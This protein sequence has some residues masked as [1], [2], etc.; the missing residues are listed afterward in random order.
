[1]EQRHPIKAVALKTG[2]SPHLIRIWERR[3]NAVSP[4]RT[5][6]NRR[7]YSDDDILRL[8][9]LRQAT[10]AGES[11]GQIAH[12]SNDSLTRLVGEEFSVSRPIITGEAAPETAAKISPGEY[13]Q[14]CIEAVARF[15]AERL[16]LLFMKASVSLGQPALMD[17]LLEPL[18]QQI[19][20]LWQDG[21]LKIA[22]EH[23]ASAVVR[24]FLGGMTG[25]FQDHESAP[26]FLA[27]TPA[28]QL[29]ELGALMAVVSARSVG[30]R[31]MYLG[32]NMQA[33]DI[34]FAATA[35]KARVVALS[36]VYPEDDPRIGR[37]LKKLRQLLAADCTIMIGGRAAPAYMPV[38]HEIGAYAS[39]NLGELKDRLIALRAVTNN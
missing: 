12:L 20:D 17:Y 31:G 37:E 18:L 10:I 5:D 21:H 13:V 25:T 6:T 1:M 32:P 4:K 26:H 38:I 39:G 7:M 35:E 9:L 29:H 23:M 28:G 24:S 27:T 15:D 8:R 16:E 14:N 11:I 30:W 22:H 2:L 36:L 19:G 33:E 3:Y 34:V